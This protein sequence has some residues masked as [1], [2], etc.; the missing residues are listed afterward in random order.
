MKNSPFAFFRKYQ[1]VGMVALTVVL[2]GLVRMA[3]AA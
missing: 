3:L 1:R 2:Y